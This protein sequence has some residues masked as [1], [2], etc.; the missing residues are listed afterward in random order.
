MHRKDIMITNRIGTMGHIITDHIVGI[1]ITII[2]ITINLIVIDHIIGITVT[3][4]H[5][6]MI[7]TMDPYG[8]IGNKS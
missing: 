1:M 6:T 5:I 8:M 3:T 4:T 7:I 2:G